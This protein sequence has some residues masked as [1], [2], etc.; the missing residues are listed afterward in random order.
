MDFLEKSIKR[1]EHWI[2]HNNQHLA[3][4]ENFARQL[5][6]AG[7]QESAKYIRDTRELNL[8]INECLN[9]ALK[10]LEG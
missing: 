5:E 10:E 2:S 4:Y 7:N 1:I 6:E 8:K 3:D 9:K